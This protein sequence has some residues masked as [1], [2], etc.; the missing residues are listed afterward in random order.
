M[1]T[2]FYV[3]TCTWKSLLPFAGLT[4]LF[5]PSYIVSSM[6]FYQSVETPPI[7]PADQAG[8]TIVSVSPEQQA[9]ISFADPLADATVQLASS[10][11]RGPADG[12]IAG[13]LA[14]AQQRIATQTAASSSSAASSKGKAGSARAGRKKSGF[15]GRWGGAVQLLG[16]AK[17][18]LN[19]FYNPTLYKAP[20]RRELTEEERPPRALGARASA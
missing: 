1:S 6:P 3:Y 14:Q 11:G 17:N 8:S 16:V 7:N 18:Q 4:N 13:D 19:K 9:E 15:W 20:E 12:D 2:T 5:Y 10:R